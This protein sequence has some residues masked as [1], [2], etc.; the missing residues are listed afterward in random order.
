VYGF[1]IAIPIVTMLVGSIANRPLGAMALCLPMA[2]LIGWFFRQSGAVAVGA[3]SL[4]GFYLPWLIAGNDSPVDWATIV[5]SAIVAMSFAW[6]SAWLRNVIDESYRIAGTDP[7]T[8]L[9]NQNRFTEHLSTE[10]NRSK[11][12]N[13]PL[14]IAYLDCDNFKI[15]NDTKGHA[16][17]DEFLKEAAKVLLLSVRNYDSVA[18][19]GGDEFAILFPG[20]TSATANIALDRLRMELSLLSNRQKCNVTWSIGVA[21]FKTMG[22]VSEMIDVADRLMYRV[23]QNEK[24]RFLVVDVTPSS[25]G[26]DKNQTPVEVFSR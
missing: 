24:D 2:A 22:D 3:L 12:D 13:L 7:L 18:R 17:G 25:N 15:L 26:N 9:F 20:M 19:M 8:K 4:V 16:A 14:A 11:R 6:M 23:K 21:C 10:V 5:T 1:F